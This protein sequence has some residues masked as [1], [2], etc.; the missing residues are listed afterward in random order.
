MMVQQHQQSNVMQDLDVRVRNIVHSVLMNLKKITIGQYS[1]LQ[2]LR[3]Y[4][5]NLGRNADLICRQ[6]RAQ[7]ALTRNEVPQ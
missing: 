7:L 4:T 6:T 1:C 5:E 2:I 3:S